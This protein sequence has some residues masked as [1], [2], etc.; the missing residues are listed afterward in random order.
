MGALLDEAARRYE[1]EQRWA[2]IEDA[3]AR[4]QRE[5]PQGWLDYLGELAEWDTTD[6]E[7]DAEA[8]EEWPE[9]NE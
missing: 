9:Y 4:L 5:N 2:D 8:A 6:A 3:Y 7:E 1:T